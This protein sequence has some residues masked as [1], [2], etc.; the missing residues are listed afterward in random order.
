MFPWKR[1]VG[2]VAAG[3]GFVFLFL[4]FWFLALVCFGIFAWTWKRQIMSFYLKYSKE[5]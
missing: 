2:V 1:V 3:I 4:K 5:V